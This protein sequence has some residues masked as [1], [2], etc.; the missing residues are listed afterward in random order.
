[1]RQSAPVHSLVSTAYF[2]RMDDIAHTLA[3]G[4]EIMLDSKESSGLSDA[5]V[6]KAA[7][8]QESRG[9]RWPWAM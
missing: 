7:G 9:E 4:V 3:A 8:C 2:G 5:W 6:F 1:M